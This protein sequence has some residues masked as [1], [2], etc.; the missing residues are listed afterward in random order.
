MSDAIAFGAVA[1]GVASCAGVVGGLPW[2]VASGLVAGP[3]TAGLTVGAATV[4]GAVQGLTEFLPVSSSGHVA[5]G[6]LLF[7]IPD[8]PL[9]TVV[10]L[11]VGTL[12]ATLLVVGKDVARLALATVRGLGR[13]R[14]FVASPEGRTVTGVLVASV[15]T[16]L[17]GLFLKSYVEQWAHL[18]AV[19]GGGLLV[20]ALLVWSTRGGDGSIEVPPL[21]TCVL[22][23]LAQ[24]LAVIPGISRS[25]STIAAGMLL[26]MR[27]SEAFRFSFLLSLP[28]VLGALVLELAEPDDLARVG[29]AGWLGGGVAFITGYGALLALRHLVARGRFW[30]FSLYLVP[31]GAGAV[32]WGIL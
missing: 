30:A 7:G 27:G 24:G 23:G 26:G 32:L 14:E 17:M 20:S 19:I 13:P 10:V 12:V 31:V 2:P 15:P 18:P 29:L 21:R 1:Q 3:G 6:A 11:H 4:L 25:G 9:A 16:A 22:L 5:L 28:A 8:L